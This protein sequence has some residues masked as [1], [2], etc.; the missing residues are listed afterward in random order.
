MRFRQHRS[1]CSTRRSSSRHLCAFG[2]HSAVLVVAAYS[3]KYTFHTL[4]ADA[5]G[6]SRETS[7]FRHENGDGIY[8]NDFDGIVGGRR[9]RLQIHRK[10]QIR[11]LLLNN[12]GEV[13]PSKPS[14]E[15]EQQD[16]DQSSMDKTRSL[17]YG[18]KGPRKDKIDVVQEDDVVAMGGKKGKKRRG[19][20]WDAPEHGKD[21]YVC[22]EYALP[23]SGKMAKGSGKSGKKGENSK[24]SKSDGSKG[25]VDHDSNWERHRAL[26]SDE[27]GEEKIEGQEPDEADENLHGRKGPRKNM[28]ADREDSVAIVSWNEEHRHEK[29][30]KKYFD[31]PDEEAV[32]I[33]WE[34]IPEVR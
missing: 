18:V 2:A 9:N 20:S 30:N 19:K 22:V 7:I 23:K 3:C 5:A 8:E 12:E 15:V 1:R 25:G 28:I 11:A 16:P 10:N 26:L 34:L 27:K 17:S 4:V 6:Q 29:K 32:C 33:K 31:E 13:E 14:D 21:G 24:G